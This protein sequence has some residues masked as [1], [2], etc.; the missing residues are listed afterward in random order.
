MRKGLILSLLLLSLPNFLAA[1][2][3]TG[4]HTG[5]FL[6]FDAGILQFDWD[7]NQ[8]TKVEE[9]REYEP[10]FGVNFGWNIFDWVAPELRVRYMT[11]RNA[12]RRE[13][14]G[15]VQIG[16]GITPLFNRLLGE[17]W[18][19]LTFIKPG[20]SLQFSG[21]PGDPKALDSM[22]FTKG[23]GPFLGFGLRFQY[24]E[25]LYFGLEMQQ[26]FH[27]Q[28]AQ[29]QLLQNGNSLEIYRGGWKSQMNIFTTIGVH[30]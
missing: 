22:I 15:A 28:E 7:V 16:V 4:F 29:A 23:I 24:H 21:L 27:F 10:T 25:Y 11:S 3:H 30:Y 18:Q 9:G 13:H 2:P 5:P 6:L 14:V 8:N 19:V 1:N 20:L 26:E 17:N 12:R